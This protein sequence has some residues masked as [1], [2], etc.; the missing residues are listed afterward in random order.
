MKGIITFLVLF[1]GL[2]L[3]APASLPTELLETFSYFS[4]VVGTFNRYLPMHEML[5]LFKYS[6]GF[7][8]LLLLWR[9]VKW[10]TEL[11]SSAV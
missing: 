5:E 8:V 9:L 6:G 10:I 11:T 1:A 2:S 3:F 7:W 4:G